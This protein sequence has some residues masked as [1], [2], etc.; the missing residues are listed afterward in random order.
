MADLSYEEALALILGHVGSRVAV[1]VG[2]A[3]GLPI[4]VS[5]GLLQRGIDPRQVLS[6]NP[7]ADRLDNIAGEVLVLG[8]GDLGAYTIFSIAEERFTAARRTRAGDREVL[9]IGQDAVFVTIGPEDMDLGSP[10]L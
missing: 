5:F 6:G 7:I 8:V 2:T 3:L 10:G 4:S 1:R 9:S